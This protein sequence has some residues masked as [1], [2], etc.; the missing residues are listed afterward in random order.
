MAVMTSTEQKRTREKKQL[1]VD[2]FVSSSGIIKRVCEKVG[3]SRETYYAWRRE[4]LR[5]ATAIREA[6]DGYLNG[7]R[8][9]TE[10]HTTAHF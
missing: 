7:T 4:D 2:L 1:V 3:I 5:F 10:V 8:N 9:L 6:V